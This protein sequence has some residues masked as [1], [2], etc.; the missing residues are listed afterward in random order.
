M[1]LTHNAIIGFTDADVR[2]AVFDPDLPG[3]RLMVDLG[4]SAGAISLT[5]DE[6]HELAQLCQEEYFAAQDIV[7]A[8][9][10]ERLEAK[11]AKAYHEYCGAVLSEDPPK[12]PGECDAEELVRWYKGSS[13]ASIG[14]MER[15]TSSLLT[16]IARKMLSWTMR[17]VNGLFQIRIYACCEREKAQTMSYCDPRRMTRGTGGILM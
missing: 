3:V 6:L 8:V 13:C 5:L 10:G 14:E 7:D 11:N 9:L 15:N 4:S 1:S 16:G 2:S 12:P 17:I